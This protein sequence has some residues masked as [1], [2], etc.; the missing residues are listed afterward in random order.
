M[1][2]QDLAES[3][4]ALVTMS[5]VQLLQHWNAVIG[6]APPQVAP[7]LLRRLIAQRMQEKRHGSLPASVRRRLLAIANGQD[8]FTPQSNPV[9]NDGMRFIRAWQGRTIEVVAVDGGFEWEGRRYG[10]LSRIA[11]EVTGAHQSGPRFFGLTG[12]GGHG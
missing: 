10:S 12:S 4:E 11:R 5:P 1:V 2:R 7:A 8:V 3:L 9:V 6:E